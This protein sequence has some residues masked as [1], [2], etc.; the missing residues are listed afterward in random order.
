M[1]QCLLRFIYNVLTSLLLFFFGVSNRSLSLP[2]S[3]TRLRG[4]LRELRGKFLR[5]LQQLGLGDLRGRFGVVGLLC[6]FGGRE[7]EKKTPGA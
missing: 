5:E 6:F 2:T 4:L 1:F 3:P 7:K